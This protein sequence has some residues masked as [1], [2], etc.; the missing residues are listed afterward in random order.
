MRTFTLNR[1]EDISGISGT[2]RIAEGVEFHDKQV[3]MSWFGKLHSIEIHP[4][5]EQLEQI[6]GHNGLTTVVW[7]NE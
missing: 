6:H 5:I 2:G 7:G 3:V 1:K 4:S